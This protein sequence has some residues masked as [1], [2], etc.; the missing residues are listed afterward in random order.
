A[1]LTGGDSNNDFIAG[2]RVMFQSAPPSR[3]ATR[4]PWFAIKAVA[5]SIRAALT[6]GDSPYLNHLVFGTRTRYPAN[7]LVCQPSLAPTSV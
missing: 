6:G 1:A 2:S 5:V 7:A 3:A 4:E